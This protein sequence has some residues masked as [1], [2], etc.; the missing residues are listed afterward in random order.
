MNY[1]KYLPLPLDKDLVCFGV[2]EKGEQFYNLSR[3]KGFNISC[4][5]DNDAAKWGTEFQGI[6]VI[7][8]KELVEKKDSVTI[9]ITNV[10]YEDQIAQQLHDLGLEEVYLFSFEEPRFQRLEKN[11]MPVMDY[12][13]KTKYEEAKAQ[14]PEGVFDENVVISITDYC[15]LQCKHCNSFMPYIENKQKLTL[16][17]FQNI[18]DTYEMFFDAIHVFTIIGG[19]PLLHP[20][21]YDMIRY[22]SE[23]D[24]IQEVAVITNGTLMVKEEELSNLNKA[25]VKFTFS[26]YGEHSKL[27]QENAAL[28]ENNQVSYYSLNHGQW[29][30]ISSDFYNR[31]ESDEENMAKYKACV[32]NACSGMYFGLFSRCYLSSVLYANDLVPY[33]ELDC[34]DL[35]LEK[36]SVE[37]I[38]KELRAYSKK[39]WLTLCRYC[40]G[41]D[42]SR[43]TSIPVGEQCVGKEASPDEFKRDI[44]KYQGM[45]KKDF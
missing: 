23:K 32:T 33:E 43:L 31:N 3:I 34:V 14:N 27:F 10:N 12:D 6:P 16:E 28:L 35:D 11:P 9:L 7:S 8:V 25:K 41:Q 19:E 21:V 26:D 1:K 42:P 29:L 44:L 4:F 36:R 22:A 24:F 5:C 38:K 20:Q 40:S 39:E 2:G 30:D 15:T 17:E 18:V 45:V 13:I 37:E